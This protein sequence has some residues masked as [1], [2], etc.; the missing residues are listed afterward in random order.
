ISKTLNRFRRPRPLS[1]FTD[2]E[3]GDEAHEWEVVSRPVTF[4]KDHEG[5]ARVQ[6]PGDPGTAR[7]KYWA[8]HD[9]IEVRR[10]TVLSRAAAIVD[11]ADDEATRNRELRRLRAESG[12][13]TR[14]AGPHAAPGLRRARTGAGAEET[15]ERDFDVADRTGPLEAGK[16]A[17]VESLPGLDVHA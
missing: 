13:R 14:K 5:R 6:R 9:K 12:S 2:A 8:A 15:P 7:E 4:K 10:S 3:P 16:Q 17:G 11:E 1:R